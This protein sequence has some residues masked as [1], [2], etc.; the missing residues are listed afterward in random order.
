[1]HTTTMKSGGE[2]VHDSMA[3]IAARVCSFQSAESSPEGSSRCPVMPSMSAN[4][5]RCDSAG[6]CVGQAMIM[7][8]QN[9]IPP[10]TARDSLPVL[11]SRV[12][13]AL[14]ASSCSSVMSTQPVRCWSILRVRLGR[15]P[16]WL[17]SLRAS[18]LH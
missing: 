2:V 15:D 11:F 16:G 12:E 18:S 10:Q 17:R 6:G 14:W 1:M 3:P 8:L 7:P 13:M 9:G 4:C 5:I